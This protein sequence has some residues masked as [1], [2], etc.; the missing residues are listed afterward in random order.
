M[1]GE[2]ESGND[3][4]IEREFYL[5]LLQL[6]AAAEPEPLIEQALSAIV[7]ASGARMAYLELRDLDD[8]GAGPPRYWKAHGCSEE[9]VATIRSSIS[10]G[11]I[12]RTL[13]EGRILSTPSANPQATVCPPR[14]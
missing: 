13:E 5:R 4:V 8:P 7:A 14:M 6:G 12:A 2:S 10:R 1:R 9:D 3:P 11:I